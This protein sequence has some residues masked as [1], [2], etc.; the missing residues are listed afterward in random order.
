MS[1]VFCLCVCVSRDCGSS[2]DS[3]PSPVQ[4]IGMSAT[5]PNLP[6]LARWLDA[7][8]YH[9]D[10]RPVPLTEMLK[11]GTDIYDSAMT[12]L[13]SFAPAVTFKGDDDDVVPLCLETTRDGHSVL[14]FCPTKN[15][16]EKLADTIARQFCGLCQGAPKC[17]DNNAETGEHAPAVH[18]KQQQHRV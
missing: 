5:L 2:P 11:I 8:L 12:K 17:G 13:R 14:V 15:W 6:L 18:A 16:C 3:T 1:D 7:D 4:I 10:Y 9:T